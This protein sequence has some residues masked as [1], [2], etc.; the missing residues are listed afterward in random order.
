MI[1]FQVPKKYYSMEN[2]LAVIKYNA[3]NIGSVGNAMDRIGVTWRIT[4]DPDEIRLASK[5]IFPGV[6]EASTT[7][8]Y[9]KDSGLGEVIKSLT[10]PVLGICLGMQLMCSGSEEGNSD[11][12]GIFPERVKKFRISEKVPHMGWNSLTELKSP[13][14]TSLPDPAWFYFVHSYYAEI[15]PSCI[16]KSG[17]GHDFAACLQKNNFYAVQFHPEKSGKAGEQV[18]NNFI[19]L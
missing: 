3:G 12:L 1:K 2:Y 9:L 16:G 8:Q 18:L 11:G 7:M 4:D 10:Q 19:S 13:L 15:G 5:V 14:L 17:H 6:G